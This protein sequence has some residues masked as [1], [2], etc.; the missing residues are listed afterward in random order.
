MYR[1][2][3]NKHISHDSL[4]YRNINNILNNFIQTIIK[5]TIRIICCESCSKKKKYRKFKYV[6]VNA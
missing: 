5:I 2:S 3:R 4:K 1:Y 6:G